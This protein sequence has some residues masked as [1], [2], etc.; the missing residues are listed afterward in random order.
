M[1]EHMLLRYAQGL[2]RERQSFQM[3]GFIAAAATFFVT[4]FVVYLL[5]LFVFGG[6]PTWLNVVAALV[7]TAA[8]WP[9]LASVKPS[10]AVPEADDW[11]LR[12]KV[13]RREPATWQAVAWAWQLQHAQVL[14]ARRDRLLQA[15]EVVQ[16][17]LRRLWY[18]QVPLSASELVTNADE[19]AIV[20]DLLPFKPLAGWRT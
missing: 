17:M 14:R 3:L 8:Q 16:G 7:V 12:W 9:L 10:T 1:E 6:W 2:E 15:D 19:Q 5:A 18:A 20:D 13:A 11:Q 4:W